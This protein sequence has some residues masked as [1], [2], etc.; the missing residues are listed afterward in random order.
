MDTDRI[1]SVRRRVEGLATG[2]ERMGWYW[3]AVGN[4]GDPGWWLPMMTRR[5]TALT[6][7]LGD[8]VGDSP[9]SDGGRGRR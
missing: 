4:D 5:I 7:A 3:A 2:F 9:R 1:D 6:A 8:A